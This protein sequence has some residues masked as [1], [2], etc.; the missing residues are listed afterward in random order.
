[1]RLAVV[2]A[3]VVGRHYAA[4]W[5]S[6]GHQVVLSFSRDPAA[7]ADR[8]ARLG[9]ESAPPREAATG[10]DVVVF[11]PPFELIADA[12]A[13][14]GPQPGTI[15]I[16]TTN[17]FTPDRT[18]IVPLAEGGTAFRAVESAFPGSRVVKALHNLAI[19]Q[20]E[21]AGSTAPVGFVAGDDPDARAVVSGLLRDAGL[22]PVET[23]DLDSARLSEAPGPLFMNL[24]TREEAEAA[25]RAAGGA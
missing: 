20:V 8:A 2:G 4:A 3:G 14:V 1:M 16:D 12:A 11:S 19:A 22:T 21:A 15:V 10:A 6:A 18:G 17:P 13:Q 7:L 25:L 5:L 24:Y 9:A 23:G